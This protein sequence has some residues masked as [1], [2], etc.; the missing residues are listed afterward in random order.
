MKIIPKHLPAVETRQ[1]TRRRCLTF[2]GQDERLAAGEE[3]TFTRNMSILGD[4]DD[5]T[6]FPSVP[7]SE[8]E[9]V[10]HI[11]FES[12]FRGRLV[13]GVGELVDEM[14]RVV[15]GLGRIWRDVLLRVRR[16]ID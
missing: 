16:G 10:K 2:D 14:A 13:Q 4:L 12:N 15:S 7:G 3:Q 11:L 6:G 8:F 9:L 5:V 1:R